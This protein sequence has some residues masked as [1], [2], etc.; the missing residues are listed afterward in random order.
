MTTTAAAL[1]IRPGLCSVTFRGE[2]V[3]RVAAASADAGLEAIE[4]GGD[5]H[6]PDPKAAEQVAAV[7]ARY[8]LAVASYGAYY[9]LGQDTHAFGTV[10]ESAVALGVPRIR[11]WAGSVEWPDAGP[12]TI[13]QV[14][15]D[16]RRIGDLAAEAGVRIGLEF[17]RNTLTATAA[18]TLN[19]LDA[20]DHR[21]VGTYWQPTVGAPDADALVELDAVFDRLEAVHVFSWWPETERLPL[22]ERSDLW[23]RALARTAADGVRRD[24]LL[25]FVPGGEL[26]TLAREAETLR[27][28]ATPAT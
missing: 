15:D 1:V 20:V 21:N 27:R 28:L 22:A 4:W 11:V 5:V 7:T 17:H 14:V 12:D 19:L 13:A 3:D 9:R 24:A 25:E 6:A 8:G 26:A 10:L 2:P 23:R 16:A 18:S